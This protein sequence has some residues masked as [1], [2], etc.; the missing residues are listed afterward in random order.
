MVTSVPRSPLHLVTDPHPDH[1]QIRAAV[2]K[3]SDGKLVVFPTETVYGLGADAL[4]AAACARIFAVKQRPA[5]NPLIVH[6]ASLAELTKYATA[7]P[8]SA[9]QLAAA[10]WPGP[11]TLLLPKASAVPDFVTAGQSTVC[12]RIPSHPVAQA[13]LAAFGGPIA[14]PSANTSGRPSATTAQDA[15][16]DL[17]GQ[18]ALIL[19]SPVV[20][21]GIE[22]TIVDATQ[23][24]PRILRPGVI[25]AEAIADVVSLAPEAARSRSTLPITPGSKYRHYTPDLEVWAMAPVTD[26][27][28]RVRRVW[29]DLQTAGRRGRLMTPQLIPGL[30][31]AAQVVLPTPERYMNQLFRQFRQAETDQIEVLIVVLLAEEGLGVG[32]NQRIRKAASRLLPSAATTDESNGGAGQS[33]SPS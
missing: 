27:A 10:F 17:G 32:V 13:L 15:A 33:S 23:A 16:Q 5:D 11:L 24:Q 19:D 18:V 25:T 2:A 20:P 31:I 30:P 4:N 3:L 26:T 28:A 22:S 1:P 9:W 12:V 7:I 6:L 14:A 21:A 29:A 8:D